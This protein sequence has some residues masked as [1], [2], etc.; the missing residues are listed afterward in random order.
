[1]VKSKSKD[2]KIA[3][4]VFIYGVVTRSVASAENRLE[5]KIEKLEEKMDKRFNK[6]MDHLDGLAKGFKKFDEEH[7]IHSQILKDHGDRFVKLE[8]IVTSAV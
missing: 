7:T 6:V 8:N 1:M 2:D 4:E 3:S 5:D